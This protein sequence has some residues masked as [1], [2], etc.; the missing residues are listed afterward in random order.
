VNRK[1]VLTALVVACLTVI[2]GFA[3]G[4]SITPAREAPAPATSPS[5]AA[6][7]SAGEGIGAE[8]AALR[9][10]PETPEEIADDEAIVEA[11]Q[12]LRRIGNDLDFTG[13]LGWP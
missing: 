3:I 7:V 8:L 13:P 6:L 11:Q 2:L 1:M 12:K 9:V 5:V 10:I 4:R